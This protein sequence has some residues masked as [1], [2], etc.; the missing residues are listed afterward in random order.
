M[1]ESQ[2]EK[3]AS[4][5]EEVELPMPWRQVQSAIWLIGLAILFWQSWWWPGILI[6]VAISGLT[7]A[8]VQ[9]YVKRQRDQAQALQAQEVAAARLPETCPVCG[10]P[11]NAR[12]AVWTSPTTATCPYCNSNLLRERAA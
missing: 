7:Q 8:L 9:V 2:N 10:A 5:E 12:S 6:L 11:V 4:Q 1:A 3:A